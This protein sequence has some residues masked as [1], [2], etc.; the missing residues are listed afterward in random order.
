[1]NARNN[2]PKFIS[3]DFSWLLMLTGKKEGKMLCVVRVY[4]FEYKIQNNNSNNKKNV[5]IAESL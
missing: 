2:V 1:M 3:K 5:C 4:L